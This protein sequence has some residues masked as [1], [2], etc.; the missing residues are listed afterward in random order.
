MARWR[1]RFRARQVEAE[2]LGMAAQVGRLIGSVVG[3]HVIS[4]RIQSTYRPL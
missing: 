2:P 4:A 1:S 3:H